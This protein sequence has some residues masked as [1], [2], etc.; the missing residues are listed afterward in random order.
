MNRLRAEEGL[1]P[2][3]IDLRLVRAAGGHARDMAAGDFL[4]HTGSDGSRPAERVL[5]E[6]YPWTAVAENVAA[7]RPSPLETV[8][9]WMTSVGHRRN[10]LWEEAEAVGVGRAE[11]AGTTYSVYWV[12]N[13]GRSADPGTPPSDGCHP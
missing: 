12:V 9:S 10:V 8:R 13:F 1:P 7:G 11:R 3:R 2:Y 5:R 4:D 6:G